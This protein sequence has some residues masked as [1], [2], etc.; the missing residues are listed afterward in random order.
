ML[1]CKTGIH[2]AGPDLE[3]LKSYEVYKWYCSLEFL[4]I[5]FLFKLVA[6]DIG[7]NYSGDP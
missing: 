4:N 3:F 5:T 2:N 7:H 1:I 6:Y